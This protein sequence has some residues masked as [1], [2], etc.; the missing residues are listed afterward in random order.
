[1]VGFTVMLFEGAIAYLFFFLRDHLK[2][3]GQFSR[4]SSEIYK[5]FQLIKIL[6]SKNSPVIN[7]Y[8]VEL[9]NKGKEALEHINQKF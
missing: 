7:K 9:L 5:L 3:F 6:I 2:E 8:T 1:M 4:V